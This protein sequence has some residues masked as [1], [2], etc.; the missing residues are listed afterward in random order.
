M[1]AQVLLAAM[2]PD[3]LDVAEL[4]ELVRRPDAGAVCIFEG[5]VRNHD[6]QARGEVVELNYSCH[7]S[8]FQLIGEIV[9]ATTA[10]IDL[11]GQAKVV[12]VHRTGR[13]SVGEVAFV[14]AVSS[15]HR[16]LAFELVQRI[17]DEVKAQ[18]PVWKQQVEADGRHSWPSNFTT[19]EES[20]C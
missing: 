16:E 3:Q 6:R 18:L 12:A 10:E 17:V 14:V 5:R 9:A 1:G 13:V 2:S 20:N 8:A 11:Q 15:P 4:T 7:P 19:D